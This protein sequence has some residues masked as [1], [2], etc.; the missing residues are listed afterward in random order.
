MAP[1]GGKEAEETVNQYDLQLFNSQS[2]VTLNVPNPRG[3]ATTLILVKE[4]A[5]MF[6][7]KWISSSTAR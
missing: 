3:T 2:F 5:I 4:T 1:H 7:A 6:S